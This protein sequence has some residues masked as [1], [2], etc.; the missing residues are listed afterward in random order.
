MT[1]KIRA[2]RVDKYACY[3]NTL[4][5]N[6]GLET[7]IWRQI[8]TSQRAHTK[9]KW[10]RYATEWT[11]P[12]KFSACATDL[13]HEVLGLDCISESDIFMMMI[14]ILST[15][16]KCIVE[17][18]PFCTTQVDET[19]KTERFTTALDV[20]WQDYRHLLYRTFCSAVGG[21]ATG[22]QTHS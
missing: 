16:R 15:D 21:W 9:W 18:H 13:G 8:V 17:T 2:V 19:Y 10:P 12:W 7:W 20:D 6:V 3:V 22:L 4:R 1:H 5:Q 14:C 11:R